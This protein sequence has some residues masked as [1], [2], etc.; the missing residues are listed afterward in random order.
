MKRHKIVLPKGICKDLTDLQFDSLIDIA[1]KLEPLWENAI[2]EHWKNR[3]D[4]ALLK[5]LYKKM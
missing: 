1:L 5:A 4:K 2:G 3:I